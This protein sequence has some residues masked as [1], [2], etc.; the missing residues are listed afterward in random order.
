M[1]AGVDCIKI[2]AGQIRYYAA[3][4]TGAY[5]HCINDAADGRELD[6]I[7]RNEVDHISHRIYST[8][9]YYGEPGQYVAS[10]RYIRECRSWRR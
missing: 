4:V 8:G 2:E 5:R 6:P 10:S 7:W 3:I 1:D 9:F